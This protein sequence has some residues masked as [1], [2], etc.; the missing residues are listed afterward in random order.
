MSK[1]QDEVT[2]NGADIEYIKHLID[3]YQQATLDNDSNVCA[4]SANRLVNYL[5]AVFATEGWDNV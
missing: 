1:K 4:I 2:L 3:C 5:N